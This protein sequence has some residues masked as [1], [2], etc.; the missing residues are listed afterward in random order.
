MAA[1]GKAPRITARRNVAELE[2]ELERRTAERD[3]ALAQQAAAAEVLQIVALSPERLEPVF[4]AILRNAVRI[5]GGTFG[6]LAIRE[7]DGFR[8]AAAHG[9]GPEF[10]ETLTRFYHPVPGTTLDTVQE[11]K[12]TI[13]IADCAAEP[14]YEPVRARNPAHAMVRTHLCVPMLRDSQLL[15]AILVYRD[16]VLPFTDRQVALIEDFAKQA[17]IAMENVRLIAETREAL[18]QQT[19]TAEVLQVINSSPA[20]L[21]SVFGAILEK[22]FQVCGGVQGSLLTF[23]GGRPRLAAARNLSPDFVEIIRK[24]WERRGPLENHPM[25][26]LAR[27]E[28]VVQILDMA[29]ADFYKNGDPTA[30][31]AVEIGNVHTV[32]FV[33]LIKDSAPLGA[34]VIARR[35]V[36]AF[37]DKEIALLQN[38]AAQ[39][40]IAIENARLI[41]ET[42]EALEQQT[43][44]AQVLSL[45]HI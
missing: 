33:A 14:A 7:G 13:Q 23:E 34:F 16:E 17:V 12:R 8:G 32:I 15:G 41:T 4:E 25:A 29:V 35:E 36:R 42:R 43:A 2:A 20:D 44:T 5:C 38:F 28:R 1:K 10:T 39:A 11:T 40:V 3:E 37:T 31:A 9:V 30:I 6:V 45:I 24:E 27:G 19:A 22:A 26:R 21:D 18:E